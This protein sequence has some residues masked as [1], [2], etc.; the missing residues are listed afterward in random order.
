MGPFL[1]AWVTLWLVVANMHSSSFITKMFHLYWTSEDC[2][3]HG[4]SPL[5]WVR[6]K[7]RRGGREVEVTNRELMGSTDGE[8][9]RD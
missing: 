5:A 9:N 2:T 6:L 4:T 7:E 8:L 1:W 3:G